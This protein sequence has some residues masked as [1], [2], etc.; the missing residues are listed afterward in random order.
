MGGYAPDT[1]E[2][3][4]GR[5]IELIRDNKWR[6]TVGQYKAVYRELTGEELY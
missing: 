1:P 2:G 4:S 3:S 6:W 5:A